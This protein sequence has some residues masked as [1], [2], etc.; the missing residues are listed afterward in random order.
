LVGVEDGD[1]EGPGVSVGASEGVVETLGLSDG[2][3]DGIE[4]EVGIALVVGAADCVG[5]PDGDTL[6]D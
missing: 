5:N 6:G 2:V 1:G 3:W 4:V